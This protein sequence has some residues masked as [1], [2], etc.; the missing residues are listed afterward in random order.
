MSRYF[1]GRRAS[2]AEPTVTL[3]RRAEE[4]GWPLG[5]G[6]HTVHRWSLP[7][8]LRGPLVL[9]SPSGQ[10]LW[11]NHSGMHQP[12]TSAEPTVNDQPPRAG[13]P[14]PACPFPTGPLNGKP[15]ASR[16]F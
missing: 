16:T 7:G 15:R 9:P 8:R 3:P 14:W 11:A 13:A 12:Y 1:K 4:V 10:V 2:L 5:A 6:R